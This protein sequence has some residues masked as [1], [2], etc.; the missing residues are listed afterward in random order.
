M[1]HIIIHILSEWADFQQ[2][3]SLGMN[4]EKYYIVVN[5]LESNYQMLLEGSLF[6]KTTEDK[7][8]TVSNILMIKS[9]R[10]SRV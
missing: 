7:A 1:L 4:E 2:W 9:N 5:T 3:S 8:F 6:W 10:E